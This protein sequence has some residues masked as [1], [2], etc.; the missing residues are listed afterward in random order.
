MDED[1]QDNEYNNQ[2]IELPEEFCIAEAFEY[3]RL[4]LDR[5]DRGGDVSLDAASV[6]RIDTAGIQALLVVQ[7]AL[8][9]AGNRLRWHGVTP[10]LKE[11]VALLGM[12]ECLALTAE[13]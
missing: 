1:G 13:A 2:H 10:Q 8:S 5:I 11:S 6:A 9:E 12:T 7:R 3:F 4:L